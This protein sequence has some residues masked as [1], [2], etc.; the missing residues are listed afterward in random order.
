MQWF[1]VTEL[2]VTSAVVGLGWVAYGIA[3]RLFLHPLANIPGPKLAALTSWYE[4]Y[5]DVVMPGKYVWKIKDL[6]SEY[7]AIIRIAPNEVHVNDLSFLDTIYAPGTH[8]RNK[9]EA[10]NLDIG[11]SVGG[12]AD[13]DLH[14]QRRE[15]L[16]TFFSKKSVVKLGPM[17]AEKVQE[18]RRRLEECMRQET[19]INLS[20]A[21]Y[22]LAID[23]VSQ[24]SFGSNDDLLGD[25]TQASVLRKNL[26]RLLL[27]VKLR[28]YFPWM[29]T[30]TKKLSTSISKWFIPPGVLDMVKFSKKIRGEIQQVLD[31]KTEAYEKRSIFCELRDNPELP[32]FE[33]SLLRLEQEGTLLV[34][35]GTESTA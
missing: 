15:A 8:R 30:I 7:G 16:S 3:Y 9:E 6:H 12:T 28:S 17:I 2:A 24:Y 34:L 27:G 4:I 5:Y 1:S 11:L 31:G 20:D 10:R 22:A 14:K 32:Q 29:V 26:T 33:K 25:L 21:Y 19:P 18:L 23:V 35:A 13:H